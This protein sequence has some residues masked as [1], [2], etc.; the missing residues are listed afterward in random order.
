MGDSDDLLASSDSDGD[1]DDLIADAKKKPVAKK[2]LQKKVSASIGS[3][4]RKIP[5]MKKFSFG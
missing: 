5:G 3:K 2:R 4:K 1:T